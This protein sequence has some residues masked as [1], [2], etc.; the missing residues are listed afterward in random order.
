MWVLAWTLN[1]GGNELPDY[2]I[3]HET[4]AQAMAAYRDLLQL[5]NLHCASVAPVKVATEPH[6]ME[7]L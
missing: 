4:E 7:A 6:W 2:W 3:I 1:L 5:D